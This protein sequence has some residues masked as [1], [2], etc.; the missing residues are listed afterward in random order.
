VLDE[1]GTTAVRATRDSGVVTKRF[2]VQVAVLRPIAGE[3]I[4]LAE[5]IASL[6][7][8]QIRERDDVINVWLHVDAS[9]RDEAATRVREQLEARLDPCEQQLVLAVVAIGRS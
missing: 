3:A 8:G 4:G 2:L 1:R 5:R 7:H 6:D 9:D